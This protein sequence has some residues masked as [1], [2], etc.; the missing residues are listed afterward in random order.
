MRRG[1]PS[2][3]RKCIVKNTAL[4][5][6]IVKPKCAPG[7][8]VSSLRGRP[9]RAEDLDHVVRSEHAGIEHGHGSGDLVEEVAV[10]SACFADTAFSGRSLGS[11]VAPSEGAGMEGLLGRQGGYQQRQ[12]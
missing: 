2:R 8:A 4:K 9:A 5:P 10:A 6:I 1:I 3:P 12:P 7:A 11:G